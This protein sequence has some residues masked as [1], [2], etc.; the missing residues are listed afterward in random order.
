MPDGQGC[1]LSA[2]G[3]RL[4]AVGC[5]LS[6]AFY[7]PWRAPSTAS[8]PLGPASGPHTGMQ[9]PHIALYAEATCIDIIYCTHR[10]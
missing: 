4:S 1:R 5:R 9:I 2:V 3:C 7:L 6:G 10:L 8:C